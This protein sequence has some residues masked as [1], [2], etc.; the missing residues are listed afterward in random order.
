MKKIG[1]IILLIGLL[2]TVFAGFSF[3]TREKVVDIGQLQITR[4]KHHHLAWTP[5]I[6]IAIML[7]GGGV[8]VVGSKKN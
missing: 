5:W 3:I 6:G 1:I 4:D 2:I 7:V 8:W